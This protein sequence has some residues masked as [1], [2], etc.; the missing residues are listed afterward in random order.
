MDLSVD[1]AHDLLLRVLWCG[2]DPVRP[3][4]VEWYFGGRLESFCSFEY[5]CS[6][7][8]VVERPVVFCAGVE[9]RVCLFGCV[10]PGGEEGGVPSCVH[11]VDAEAAYV[12]W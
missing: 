7:G 5:V 10:S 9:L 12:L 11:V 8:G 6:G 3:V 1:V 2:G 4:D